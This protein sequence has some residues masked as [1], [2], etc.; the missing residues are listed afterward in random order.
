MPR[1]KLY[2]L[3]FTACLLGSVYLYL[4]LQNFENRSL[5]VCI[6]KN[7]TGIP[8]PSCGTT[9]AV[10]LLLAGEFVAS[11]AANPFGILVAIIM[12][13]VPFWILFDVI[14]KKETLLTAYRKI[15]ETVRIKWLAALLIVLVLLNWIWNIYKDV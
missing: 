8:C 14:F 10:Q 5:N 4:S 6:I 15:E 7:V 3:L 12:A 2:T 13:I 11:V 1:N 9:R